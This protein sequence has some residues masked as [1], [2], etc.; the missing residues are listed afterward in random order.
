MKLIHQLLLILSLLL[1]IYELSLIIIYNDISLSFFILGLSLI[2]ALYCILYLKG[3]IPRFLTMGMMVILCSFLIIEGWII[4]ESLEKKNQEFDTI[5][6]LGAQVK[7]GRPSPSLQYRIDKA[8][9]LMMENP[10]L[11][12]ILSGAQG[13]DESLSEARCMYEELRDLPNEM[14]LEENSTSTYEN[15]LY[16]KEYFK[17]KVGVISNSF[18]LLRVKMI[19]NDLNLDITTIP[20]KSH[21]YTYLH[22]LIRE[23]F[24]V[25]KE[26]F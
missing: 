16:S 7:N 15:L 11:R 8:R 12:V 14:I 9:D 26:L 3:W 1:S 22:F 19:A 20:A 13:P 21:R 17:G 2:L 10:Q 24:G 5:V 4:M 6:V 23:Y 25:L 18:H